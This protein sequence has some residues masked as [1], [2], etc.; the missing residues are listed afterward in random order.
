[1]E[2]EVYPASDGLTSADTVDITASAN[3]GTG[4]GSVSWD[5]TCNAHANDQNY[6]MEVRIDRESVDG[7]DRGND[8]NLDFD[9]TAPNFVNINANQGSVDPC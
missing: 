7:I 5:S 4:T 6:D 8:I 3:G 2:F 1:M 9:S